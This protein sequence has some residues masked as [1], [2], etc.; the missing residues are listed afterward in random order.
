MVR[1]WPG[2]EKASYIVFFWLIMG[3]II[4]VNLPNTNIMDWAR[5]EAEERV[6]RRLR[7]EPVEYG[8]NYAALRVMQEAGLDV[9]QEMEA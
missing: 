7:G 4:Y 6:R 3:P 2:W 8:M 1:E 9:S 5:D